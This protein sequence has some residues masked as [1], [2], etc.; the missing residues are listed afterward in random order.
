MKKITIIIIAVLSLLISFKDAN[1]QQPNLG[2]HLTNFNLVVIYEEELVPKDPTKQNEGYE[3]VTVS[4]P[5]SGNST[6]GGATYD[7][8]LYMVLDPTG[9]KGPIEIDF[10]W[11]HP[12][13][14]KILAISCPYPMIISSRPE[15]SVNAT[16][17]TESFEGLATCDFCPDGINPNNLPTSGC[18]SGQPSNTG[19]PTGIA[20]LNFHGTVRQNLNPNSIVS[21]SINGTVA[22]GGF[23]YNGQGDWASPNCITYSDFTACPAIFTGTFGATLKPCPLIDPKG[24]PQCRNL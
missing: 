12:S 23:D 8:I 20:Y 17:R 9:D 4:S 16:T 18:N 11:K 6:I 24:D 13:G 14:S 1:A 10:Y 21:L 3:L 2:G 22:G 5:I 7:P 19:E 15:T